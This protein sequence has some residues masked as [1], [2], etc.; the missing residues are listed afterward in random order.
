MC[1]VVNCWIRSDLLAIVCGVQLWV[2]HFPIG[3]LGQV[4]YLIVSIPDL[5]TRTYFPHVTLF[6]NC[7]NGSAPLNRK[8]TRAT[9][10]IFLNN[11]SSRTTDPNSIY[12]TELFLMMH[13]TRVLQ[14]VPLHW[15]VI[16]SWATQGLRTLLF[17]L[18]NWKTI[19]YRR[20]Y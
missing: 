13:S 6:Q 15:S 3:I 2:C 14:M 12:F 17:L 16:L 4:W 1:L 9:D 11:I 8:A 5:C 20:R 7:I 10:K 18:L 19:T